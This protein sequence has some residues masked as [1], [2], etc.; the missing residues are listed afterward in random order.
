VRQQLPPAARI[1][2]IAA[3]GSA[4]P[5]SSTAVSIIDSVKPFAP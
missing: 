4:A 2:P 1:S 5:P 3:A